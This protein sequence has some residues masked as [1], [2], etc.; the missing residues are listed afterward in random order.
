MGMIFSCSSSSLLFLRL[1][2]VKL[3]DIRSEMARHSDQFM[4]LLKLSPPRKC[5][6]IWWYLSGLLGLLSFFN[7]RTL[8]GLNQRFPFQSVE[9]GQ[10]SGRNVLKQ[11]GAPIF[12][13]FRRFLLNIHGSL[14]HS[15]ESS[16]WNPKRKRTIRN[17]DKRTKNKMNKIGEIK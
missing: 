14:W 16:E 11:C 2:G 10:Y 8:V 9:C 13:C 17:A 12:S 1:W 5:A 6:S 4:P 7:S 3:F 15:I